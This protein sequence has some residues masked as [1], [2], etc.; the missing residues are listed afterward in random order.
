MRVIVHWPRFG[1]LHL[2]RMRAAHEVLS[3]FGHEAVALE[4]ASDDA[5]YD[6]RQE[7]GI[8]LFR[9]E[10]LFPGR[11]YDHLT[12]R[13]LD[14]AVREAL[15]R[16]NPGAV[17]IHS[18]STPD[19]RAA[20]SWCRARRRIAICMAESK[21]SDAPRLAWR[22]S[23]KRQL[24]AQFD[25]A[26]ASGSPGA[27][28][29]ADLGIP[30]E[31]IFIGYSVVDNEYFAQAAALYR[32]DPDLA[33]GLPGLDS[34][35]PFFFAS[36]RFIARKDLPTLI[37]AYADYREAAHEPWRLVLLGDG[38]LR[39]DIERLLAERSVGGVTLAGWQQIDT[40]PAYYALASAFVHTAKV[41]QWGLVV[42]EA[43]AA[44][45]PVLVSTGAG[46]HED[47]VASGRNGY[48]FEPEDRTRLAYLL[49]EI[50]HRTDLAAFGAESRDIITQFPLERFG[51]SLLAAI[52]AGRSSA[53]Q[54]GRHI[55][56]EI[57]TWAL[58]TLARSPRAFHAIES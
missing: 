49:D 28:Y 17:L 19:A 57:I 37:H 7:S 13:Q 51:T 53:P 55:A 35:V 56:A 36:S 8:S 1:P 27:R 30:S 10:T 20:V 47:L 43:M 21:A 32:A 41:D 16:L 14:R 39:P 2:N 45:L 48:T 50:A 25:A 31:R 9:R 4:I 23:L 40:L 26:Q 12:P 52:D 24:V 34:P 3:K 46:C 6:W 15:N 5:I 33:R 22:E 42:N 38:V 11:N 44:G 58:R 54:H 18:Y 29:H